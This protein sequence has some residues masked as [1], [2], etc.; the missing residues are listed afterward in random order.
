VILVIAQLIIDV[1]ENKD[2][3]GNSDGEP[4]DVDE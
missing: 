4:G 1:K 2:T 3:A